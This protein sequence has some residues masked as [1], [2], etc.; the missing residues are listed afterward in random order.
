ML[1]PM[2]TEKTLEI[3]LVRDDTAPPSGRFSVTLLGHTGKGAGLGAAMMNLSDQLYRRLRKLRE[4]ET[5]DLSDSAV[6]ERQR[7]AAVLGD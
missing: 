6:L 3:D 7:L 5:A 1:H 2:P 4:V